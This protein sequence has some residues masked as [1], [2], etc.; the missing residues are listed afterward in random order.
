[1]YVVICRKHPAIIYV[2]IRESYISSL[3]KAAPIGPTGIIA[4]VIEQ[5][6]ITLYYKKT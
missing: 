4:S 2:N 1:M 5:V 6:C 3:R